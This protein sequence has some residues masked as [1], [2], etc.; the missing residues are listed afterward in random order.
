VHQQGLMG[1]S[2]SR[3]FN[4]GYYNDTIQALHQQLMLTTTNHPNPLDHGGSSDYNDSEVKLMSHDLPS[5]QL[6]YYSCSSTSTFQPE[7]ED[8]TMMMTAWLEQQEMI[9]M[10][11][12]DQ[13]QPNSL[14]FK[15]EYVE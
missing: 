9:Q 12:W 15:L 4:G 8:F 13:T 1:C 6:S 7:R 10:M 2:S 14:A 11:V 5:S 3:L